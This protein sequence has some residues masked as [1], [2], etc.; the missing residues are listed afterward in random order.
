MVNSETS[1]GEIWKDYKIKLAAANLRDI[2]DRLTI[3]MRKSVLRKLC[4]E[5]RKNS[6]GFIPTTINTSI[7]TL[8]KEVGLVEIDK[9]DDD[10][11]GIS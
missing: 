2:L 7:P 1:L 8:V 11:F 5:A 10:M 3:L 4:L 6:K 9:D